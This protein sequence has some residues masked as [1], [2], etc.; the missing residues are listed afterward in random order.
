MRQ[1]LALL[2][3]LLLTGCPPVVVDLFPRGVPSDDD[4]ASDDDDTSDDDDVVNSEP[5][6]E[7]LGLDPSTLP[8]TGT[9]NVV[10]RV[11]D[12]D[13]SEYTLRLEFGT[14]G[15]SSNWSAAT[16]ENA[17][18]EPNEIFEDVG[19]EGFNLSLIHI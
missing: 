19:Q 18:T 16:V 3:V 9:V 15:S 6:V 17:T 10:I 2:F 1:T 14:E 11:A 8:V 13:S 12:Q 7:I 4:D 5:E